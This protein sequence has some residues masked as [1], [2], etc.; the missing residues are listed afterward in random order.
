MSAEK[1]TP[2]QSLAGWLM[3]QIRF[4]TISE[5]I[6]ESELVKRIEEKFNDTE[7]LR[8]QYHDKAL[9]LSKELSE[10]TSLATKRLYFNSKILKALLDLDSKAILLADEI[11]TASP[12][13]IETMRMDL[14]NT[15]LKASELVTKSEWIK[16][17]FNSWHETHFEIVQM[18]TLLLHSANVSDSTIIRRQAE[19]GHGGLYELAQE[20]TDEFEKLHEGHDWDGEFFDAVEEFCTRKNIPA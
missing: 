19:Q 13:K 11:H 6:T 4:Y 16:L 7:S 14:H 15:H 10:W 12:D 3:T 20:W 9:Q 5:A 18:I 8:K 1:Q 17:Q 2:K